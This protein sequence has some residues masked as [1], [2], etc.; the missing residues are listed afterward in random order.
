[1]NIHELM[2][3]LRVCESMCEM[4]FI[5]ACLVTV[6][7]CLSCCQIMTINLVSRVYEMSLSVMS[8]N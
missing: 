2:C 6:A 8:D 5:N 7:R 1:M 3:G 4:F